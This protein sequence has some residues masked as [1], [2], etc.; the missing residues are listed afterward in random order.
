MTEEQDWGFSLREVARRAKVSHSAPYNHFADKGELL[1]AVAAEG[2]AALRARLLAAAA[3]IEDAGVALAAT[4]CAYVGQGVKNPA[5]YRLMFG[6]A[7]AAG[8][9][10]RPEAARVAGAQARAVLDA[11]ILRGARSRRLL[12]SPP[13]TRTRSISPP[14]RPGRPFT[15]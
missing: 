15:A 3:G 1:G 12:R 7:L 8:S 6:E 5:L 13:M 4:A 14:C 2:F 10:D 11:V 9:G